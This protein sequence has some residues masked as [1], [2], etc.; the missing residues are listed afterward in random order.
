M[1]LNQLKNTEEAMNGKMIR[2]FLGANSKDGFKSLFAELEGGADAYIIKGGPGTGKSS[3]MKKFASKAFAKG[4]FTEYIYCSSDPD[5]LDGVAVDALNMYMADGTAPHTIEPKYPGAAGE[6]I[7]LGACWNDKLLRR[8]KDDVKMLSGKI[9]SC[10]AQGYRY[11]SAAGS[12]VSDIS[13]C[14]RAHLDTEKLEKFTSGFITRNIPQREGSGRIKTRFL[15][16]ITPKGYITF[17]DTVYTL[18]DRLFTVGDRFFSSDVILSKI[19]DAAAKNGYTVWDFRSPL[20]PEKSEHIVIEELGLGIATNNVFCRFDTL[21]AY[22]INFSRFIS[23][24][25]T[26]HSKK[27]KFSARMLKL[28]VDEAVNSFVTAKSLH[29]DLEEIYIQAMD[30][31]KTDK[32]L[33]E[34]AK[35]ILK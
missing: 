14:A 20:D 1:A 2:T 17:K 33:E 3:F 8:S 16:G 12:L 5:S 28:C 9:S 18:C 25:I 10:F 4:C 22:S 19:R 15:S 30:F 26:Q 23:E 7:N 31:S 13:A 29:D 27:L 34:Y 6:I 11:L 32:I 24:D 21:A 35:K